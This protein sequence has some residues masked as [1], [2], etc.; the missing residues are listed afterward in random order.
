MYLTG[1]MK[2]DSK[3]GQG[4][5]P[6]D[7]QCEQTFYV[8]QADCEN[9]RELIRALECEPVRNVIANWQTEIMEDPERTREEAMKF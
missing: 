8:L 6:A 7:E 4:R 9:I 3:G 1:L 5:E 2:M